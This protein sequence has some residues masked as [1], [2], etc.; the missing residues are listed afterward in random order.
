MRQEAAKE[1][2]AA[3]PHRP[4]QVSR[5]IKVKLSKNGCS[6]SP[7]GFALRHMTK[8]LLSSPPPRRSACPPRPR[9]PPNIPPHFPAPVFEAYE[10]EKA[11]AAFRNYTD[12]ARQ[13]TVE[14]FYRDNHSKQT[15]E[16]VLAM[17]KKYNGLTH[18]EMTVW[19][20]RLHPPPPDWAGH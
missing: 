20:V 2:A 15:F 14:S 8:P 6:P 4:E 12:S 1:N 10:P 3:G 13:A 5:S 7:N 19:E 17:E 11:K 9:L 16:H 18:A